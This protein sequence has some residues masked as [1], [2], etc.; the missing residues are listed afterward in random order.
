MAILIDAN[1]ICA[2]ANIDD[3]HNKR[4]TNL[5]NDVLSLKYGKVII[6]DYVFDEIITVALRRTSHMNSVELGKYLMQ[7]EIY[8]VHIDSNVFRKSWRF[9]QKYQKFSFTDCSI[10]AFMDLFKVKN[11][12]TFDKKFKNISWIRVID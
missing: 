10:L 1:V 11:L 6:T 9:F 2:F 5:L 7:S 8:M 3:V 4:A 12:A